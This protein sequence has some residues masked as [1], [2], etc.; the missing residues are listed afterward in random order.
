MAEQAVAQPSILTRVRHSIARALLRPEHAAPQRKASPYSWPASVVNRPVWKMNDFSTYV[1]EGFRRNA[2]YYSAVMYKCRN[3]VSAPLRA[4]MGDPDS[5]EIAPHDHPLS[6]LATRPNAYQSGAEFQALCI[7]YQN[8][9]GS[10]FIFLDRGRPSQRLDESLPVAL[11][12]LRPDRVRMIPGPRGTVKGWLY[13]RGLANPDEWL[14]ILPDDLIHVNMPNPGDDFESVGGGMSPVRPSAQSGDVDNLVT[15]FLKMFFQRGAM[16][17]GLITFD[18]AIGEEVAAETR[19]RFMEIYGGYENWSEVAVLGSGAN[20]ERIGLTF[21][22]MGFEA[23]DKRNAARVLMVFGVPG[24]L[25]SE[26]TSM[27][28]AILNNLRELRRVFWEDTFIPE[29][30]L[31][32]EEYKTHLRTQD[33]AWL[34]FDFA[35]VPA[36]QRDV[37]ELTTAAMNLWKSSVPFY[38]AAQSVGLNV[39]RYDGDEVSYI[40]LG[41]VPAT[42]APPAPANGAVP[43]PSGGAATGGEAATHTE[44]LAPDGQEEER[45]A[46][47]VAEVKAT[48]GRLT[49]EQKQQV[50][51]AVDSIA[52]AWEPRFEETAA[53]RFEA[54]KR[55]LLAAVTETRKAAQRQKATIGYSEMLLRWQ[56][57]MRM[58]GLDGWR[59]AFIP[60]IEAVMAAQNERWGATFGIQFDVRNLYAEQWFRDYTLTF[61]QPITTTTE[62]VL[63]GMMEQAEREG[64]S[65]PQVERALERQFDFWAGAPGVDAADLEFIEARMPL[66]RREIIARV[67]TLRASN[68]GSFE[69]FREWGAPMKE[70]LATGD[71]RTRD[72]HLSAW[73]RYQEGGDPGPI[74]MDAPFTVGGYSMMYPL[75]MSLGAPLSEVAQCRCTVLPFLEEV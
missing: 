34:Q 46:Q 12:T 72:T 11:H 70:W 58:A 29:M 56:D 44:D 14:P 36:L 67:E 7:A 43:P 4:Y 19:E 37:P 10:A 39:E 22:E 48:K 45:A 25:L 13:T 75:D 42:G 51:R 52:R 24:V 27:D 3:S 65:I 23:I 21:D 32:E 15:D 26:P 73:M 31:F 55:A 17:N 6:L 49:F 47:P 28:R 30:R 63:S 8:L 64:W 40:T 1:E 18:A 35:R 16:F 54:D 61:A 68:S 71:S 38:L 20:Y 9:A 41:T 57:Y 2:L 33:G 60:L 59:S 69:L 50:W 53:A 74:P 66:H 62:R 5:P